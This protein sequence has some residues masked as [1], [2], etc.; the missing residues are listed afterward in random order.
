MG[1]AVGGGKEEVG[2]DVIEIFVYYCL[3]PSLLLP[4]PRPPS[5]PPLILLLLLLLLLHIHIHIQPPLPPRLL[6][7]HACPPIYH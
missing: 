6:R 3:R 2:R 7:L 1:V 4:L 5:P